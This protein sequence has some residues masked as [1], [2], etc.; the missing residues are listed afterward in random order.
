[1]GLWLCEYISMVT[2]MLCSVQQT[3]PLHES[4][5]CTSVYR[6]HVSAIE[7]ENDYKFYY[8]PFHNFVVENEIG[9]VSYFTRCTVI[10]Q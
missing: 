9:M 1:M 10:G 7:T 6:M 4:V 2:G 5:N 8:F 3:F